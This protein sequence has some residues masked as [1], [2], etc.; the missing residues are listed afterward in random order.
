MEISYI[1]MTEFR[2]LKLWGKAD[3]PAEWELRKGDCAF[4]FFALSPFRLFRL[5]DAGR[6]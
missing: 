4:D 1:I 5:F 3:S 6:S 2:T